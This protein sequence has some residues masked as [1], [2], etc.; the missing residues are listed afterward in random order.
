MGTKV[1]SARYENFAFSRLFPN[2]R[3]ATDA[4]T[5]EKCTERQF[6]VPS[7]EA[8]MNDSP[9]EG[10]SALALTRMLA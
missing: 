2:S 10:D 4:A 6:A 3:A 7:L 9:L 1:R 5:L 8:G